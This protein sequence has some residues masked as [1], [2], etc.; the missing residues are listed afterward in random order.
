MPVLI[1]IHSQIVAVVDSSAGG[2]VDIVISLRDR[3]EGHVCHLPVVLLREDLEV[4]PAIVRDNDLAGR[5]FRA[6]CP[7]NQ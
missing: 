4:L 2:E 5:G 1:Q 7:D 6:R 3:L